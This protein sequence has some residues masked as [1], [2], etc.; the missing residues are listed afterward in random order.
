[1]AKSPFY[2]R[3]RTDVLALTRAVPKGRVTSF[4]SIGAH[5]EVM[6]RHVAY[7]LA[8]LE[9]EEEARTPWYRVVGEGGALGKRKEN[10]FGI[11]QAEL[12]AEE[13]VVVAGGKILA[14]ADRFIETGTLKSGV[15]PQKRPADAPAGT[16]RKR[17]R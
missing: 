8:T 10:A 6:P 9:G 1:M 15:P 14:F 12:L 17:R 4:A 16:P 11:S 7:I 5:L 3:I 2:A 13:G